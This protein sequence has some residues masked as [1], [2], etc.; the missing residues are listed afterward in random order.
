MRISDWSSDVCSSDLDLGWSQ[1]EAVPAW[2]TPRGAAAF[3][4]SNVST[5][6]VGE[7]VFALMVT[8][9]QCEQSRSR[10]PPRGTVARFHSAVEWLGGTRG[11]PRSQEDNSGLQ[12]L[13]RIT[14]TVCSSQQITQRS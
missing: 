7:A 3:T 4:S 6:P 12:S 13:M 9:H 8:T 10:D 5:K 1:Y 2:L 11:S 14:D